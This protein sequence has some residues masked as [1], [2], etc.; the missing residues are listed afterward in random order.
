LSNILEIDLELHRKFLCSK[1][2]KPILVASGQ[3]CVIYDKDICL[4][5]GVIV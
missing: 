2:Q 3:S 1:I 5:G 4:G